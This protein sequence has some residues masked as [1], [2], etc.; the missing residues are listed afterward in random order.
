MRPAA[1]V[2]TI[3][4]LLV[5]TM[6]AAVGQAAPFAG[7][8][9]YVG[10]DHPARRQAAE[11]RRSRPADAER[12]LRIAEQPQARWL[13]EWTA[14]VRGEVQR[15]TT[16][17]SR[18]RAV[19]VLVAYNIPHRDCG[20]Y[21]RGGAGSP[22]AYRRWILEIARGIDGRPAIVILEPDAV[23]ALDCLPARLRDERYVLVRDAADV[24]TKAG[25]VVYIDAGHSNWQ[26]PA[27]MATRLT[28]AG[29][30]AAR[31]FAL[32]VSNFQSTQRSIAYG[33]AVSRLTRG[34][35]YII[36]TSRNGRGAEA[37]ANWCNPPGQAIGPTPTLRTGVALADAYLWVKLPGES[38]GTCNNG[39]RAGQWW[40]EYALGLVR[41]AE[42][43]RSTAE[44]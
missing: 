35:H 14:N 5:A 23:P 2:A 11:W 4:L 29:V 15:I 8:S 36:D 26:R 21:S 20:L 19:P 12:M 37:K 27:E 17:A 39:P 38:D 40:P 31:G 34:K 7:R 9:L 30:P 41:T 42:T 18:A 16:E 32:N 3:G 6:P 43:L 22:D 24:L 28:R 10:A 13:G 1:G 33:D 25:A 44:R